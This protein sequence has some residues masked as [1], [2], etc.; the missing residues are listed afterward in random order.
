[1]TTEIKQKCQV[2]NCNKRARFV[3]ERS[4]LKYCYFHAERNAFKIKTDANN[5]ARLIKI[6][7]A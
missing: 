4:N 2:A 5:V 1:M 7:G 6:E 3:N